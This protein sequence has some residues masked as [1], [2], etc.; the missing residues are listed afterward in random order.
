L[1][2]IIDTEHIW[3][4]ISLQRNN[5]QFIQI[6]PTRDFDHELPTWLKSKRI[7]T[8]EIWEDRYYYNKIHDASDVYCF[9]EVV[10]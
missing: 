6:D 1:Q 2:K 7:T 9:M 10:L 3:R 8:M 5:I 4:Q